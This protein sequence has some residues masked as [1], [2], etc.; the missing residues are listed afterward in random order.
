[1]QDEFLKQ[2]LIKLAEQNPEQRT[3]NN[4][5]L[6]SEKVNKNNNNSIKLKSKE[7]RT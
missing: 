7:R 4:C 1:M 3:N 2:K 5:R 6:R